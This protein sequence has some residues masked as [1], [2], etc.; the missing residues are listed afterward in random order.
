[1]H[2]HT[3]TYTHSHTNIGGETQGLGGGGGLNVHNANNTAGTFGAGGGVPNTTAAEGG[4][5][6]PINAAAGILGTA[7]TGPGT[8]FTANGGLI[9]GATQAVGGGNQSVLASNAA[10]LLSSTSP[11]RPQPVSMYTCL[12]RLVGCLSRILAEGCHMLW[13]DF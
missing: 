11:A 12:S 8:L 7:A 13:S 10:A 5:T 1:M 6:V 4:V 2:A 3:H 9:G